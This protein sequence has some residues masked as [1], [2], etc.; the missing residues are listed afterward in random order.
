MLKRGSDGLSTLIPGSPLLVERS[1]MSEAKNLA[2]E[3]RHSLYGPAWHGPS[4]QEVLKG[5]D[6]L[7]ANTRMLGF[8][9]TIH[10]IVLHII[11]WNTVA[12]DTLSGKVYPEFPFPGDWPDSQAVNWEETVRRVI[13][14]GETLTAAASCLS[15]EEIGAVVPDRD[16][17]YYVMLHGVAQH[18]AYHGGQIALLKKASEDRCPGVQTE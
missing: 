18:N 13:T 4:L 5:I 3:L 7:Q 17:S 2:N 6:T 1:K 9:H 15:N 10:E 11:A 12:I 8:T 16:F 14:S